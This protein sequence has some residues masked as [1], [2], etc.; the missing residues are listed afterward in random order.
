MLF[1]IGTFF[2]ITFLAGAVCLIARAYAFALTHVLWAA[3]ECFVV[4]TV[5]AG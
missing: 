4:F 2:V 1:I 5:H 3:L